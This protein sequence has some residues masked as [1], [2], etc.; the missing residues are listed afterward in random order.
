MNP[1]VPKPTSK[2]AKPMSPDLHPIDPQDLDKLWSLLPEQRL[3][4]IKFAMVIMLT[5]ALIE[6]DD[7]LDYKRT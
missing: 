5:E 7:P 4:H 2:G 3:E 1:S 6:G